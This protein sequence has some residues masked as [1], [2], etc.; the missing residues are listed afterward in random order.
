MNPVV[1]DG[2]TVLDFQKFTF[3]GH[4]RTHVYK[5]LDENIKL[6]HA[7][8]AGYWTLELLC[9]GLVHSMWQTL[10]ESSAKHINRAAP[11]VFL[12][13]VQAYEKFAPYESQ[14]SLMAMTDMR[15]NIPVRQMV[16]EA[17]ATVALTRK[18]K[19]MSLPTIK[20]E[21]DFQQVTITEN[22]KAP[23]SNYVRLLLKE[24][25]PMD[26]YVSLNEMAYCLR[27]EARDFTRAIYWMSWILKF[28]SVFKQTNKR[29]LE[30]SY[31]PNP[32]IDQSHGRHVVW[33]FWDIVQNASRSSPQAGVLNPYIDA[34][35]KLHCLR[36]NP[37]VMKARCCFLVCACLYICESNTLD[38][39]YPVPQDIIAVK[40]IVESTPNWIHSI[41]QTQKTFST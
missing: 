36:W 2:R 3:S 6:G 8:Y 28:A 4:L 23:S 14:Y 39:H 29:P 35:Y 7:D 5:V 9:S 18:H 24:D 21:H 27:P 17:A 1:S 37:S 31:R 16:C 19:L 26:L 25:D 34:L 10:F 30:C 20:P 22:L 11:N 12:Y 40:G 15:N 32:Y 13:L 38:I 33:I 41:I